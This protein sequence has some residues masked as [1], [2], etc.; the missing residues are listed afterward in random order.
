MKSEQLLITTI[1]D[2]NY[3]IKYYKLINSNSSVAIA[4]SK[5]NENR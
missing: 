4:F 3:A 5:T 1:S 2:R